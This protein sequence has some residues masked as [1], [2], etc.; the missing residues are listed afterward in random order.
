MADRTTPV[1]FRLSDQAVEAL[2]A[3]ARTVSFSD[4]RDIS[5]VDLIRQSISQQ[6][7]I[8]IA[9]DTSV[10]LAQYQDPDFA[11]FYTSRGIW[12]PETIKE[13]ESTERGKMF[14]KCI[15]DNDYKPYAELGM[16][17]L[18]KWIDTKSLTKKILSSGR[19]TD[20]DELYRVCRDMPSIA[21]RMPRRGEFMT[22]IM[23]RE[24]ILVPTDAIGVRQLIK[25]GD[26]NP[27]SMMSCM[28]NGIQAVCRELDGNCLKRCYDAVKDATNHG[29]IVTETGGRYSEQGIIEAI[30]MVAQHRIVPSLIVL[31]ITDYIEI[32]SMW[33]SILKAPPLKVALETGNYGTIKGITVEVTDRAK[34]DTMLVCGQPS[35]VGVYKEVGKPL[36]RHSEDTGKQAQNV[37]YSC[38]GE[39][40]IVNDWAL[41]YVEVIR[42]PETK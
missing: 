7:N 25:Y 18:G 26:I 4:N 19:V 15:E 39:H 12:S 20:R 2:K 30:K 21:G 34:Q 10:A 32:E 11:Y 24:E 1:T 13:F 29:Q 17:L 35:M 8:D 6:Y 27:M 40:C 5:Y 38:Q 16:R 22:N 41:S 36:V 14:R 37:A 28:A 33:N 23:E 3:K 42:N 9:E 31:S